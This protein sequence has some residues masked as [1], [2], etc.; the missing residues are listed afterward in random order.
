MEGSLGIVFAGQ[1][2]RMVVPHVHARCRAL[3]QR[4]PTAAMD[5]RT[6]ASG[7]LRGNSHAP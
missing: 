1:L 7:F 6:A 2:E 4:L 3:I 5:A